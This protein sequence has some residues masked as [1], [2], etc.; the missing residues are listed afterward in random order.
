MEKTSF[1]KEEH[2]RT[3]KKNTQRNPGS[4][5]SSHIEEKCMMHMFFVK[6]VQPK[7]H[8]IIHSTCVNSCLNDI[9][10]EVGYLF[11]IYWKTTTTTH[12]HRM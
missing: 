2:E 6:S 8:C 5:R 12:I 9:I 11:Y 3:Q 1:G 7:S 10:I 4:D